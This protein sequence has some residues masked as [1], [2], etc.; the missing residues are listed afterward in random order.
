MALERGRGCVD[1]LEGFL[2]F[3]GGVRTTSVSRFWQTLVLFRTRMDHAL[4]PTGRS[5]LR[6][7]LCIV[8]N[9]RVAEQWLC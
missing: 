1:D 8:I 7:Q 9:G 3:C 6:L 5:L 4:K 2:L